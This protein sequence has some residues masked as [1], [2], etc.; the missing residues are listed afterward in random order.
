M[1]RSIFNGNV[2]FY[3]QDQIFDNYFFFFFFLF[4]SQAN[5]INESTTECFKK[6]FRVCWCPLIWQKYCDYFPSLQ[7]IFEDNY[8]V[9]NQSQEWKVK[10]KMFS[11]HVNSCHGKEQYICI[12]TK[13]QFLEYNWLIFLN[14]SFFKSFFKSLFKS[15]NNIFSV[16]WV[17]LRIFWFC[18]TSVQ[19]FLARIIFK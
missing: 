4:F 2:S 9:D 12:P 8:I 17:S 16:F 19:V 15:G 6:E 18:C 5:F 7:L 3:K 13:A 10:K 11:L 14:T 1:N